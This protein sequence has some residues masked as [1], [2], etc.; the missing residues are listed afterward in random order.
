MEGIEGMLQDRRWSSSSLNPEQRFNLQPFKM[1]RDWS[2]LFLFFFFNSS[3]TPL[4]SGTSHNITS[5]PALMC[6][7]DFL[8]NL[9]CWTRR[10]TGQ[11]SGLTSAQNN[12]QIPVYPVCTASFRTLNP[13]LRRKLSEFQWF[14]AIKNA[15]KLR[16]V[17]FP[18]FQTISAALHAPIFCW[19]LDWASL[20]G[21]VFWLT[22]GGLTPPIPVSP[23]QLDEAL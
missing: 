8:V 4:Q 21:F 16:C 18:C 5:S 22:F 13:T 1:W 10:Q 9:F 2:C 23:L 15:N 17:C 3:L 20:H 11:Q 6:C 7:S 14:Y 19:I 12:V